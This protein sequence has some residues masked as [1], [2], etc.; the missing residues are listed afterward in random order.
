[1]Q[2][3]FRDIVAARYEATDDGLT[4]TWRHLLPP[5]K[6]SADVLP[7]VLPRRPE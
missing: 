4:S 2:H 3:H 7:S 6:G 1:L 5:T